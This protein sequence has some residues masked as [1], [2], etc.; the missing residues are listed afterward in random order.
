MNVLNYH[1]SISY[2]KRVSLNLEKE[3]EGFLC[4]H[5]PMLACNIVL[6]LSVPIMQLLLWALLPL[7]TYSARLVAGDILYPADGM[8][9]QQAAGQGRGSASLIHA[10][11]L[12]P[13]CT[14]LQHPHQRLWLQLPG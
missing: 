3:R 13:R 1:Y 6:L 10:S 12:A 5:L 11:W 4:M 7:L 2:N 9:R 14:C 8:H